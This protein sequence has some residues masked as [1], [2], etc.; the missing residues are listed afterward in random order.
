MALSS[1]LYKFICFDALKFP[2]DADPGTSIAFRQASSETQVPVYGS[3]KT[4]AR[5]G[6]ALCL[7]VTRSSNVF[8]V[9]TRKNSETPRPGARLAPQ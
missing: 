9:N 6:A 8:E 4:E 5:E 3:K 7:R 2:V 1:G